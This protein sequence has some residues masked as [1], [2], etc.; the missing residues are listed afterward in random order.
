MAGAIKKEVKTY[1]SQKYPRKYRHLKAVNKKNKKR[2]E[3]Y[4]EFIKKVPL[5]LC[6]RLKRII[7]KQNQ[8]SKKAKKGNGKVEFIKQVSLHPSD[9]LKK[10]Q[11]RKKGR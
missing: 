11:K 3:G 6:E 9:R 10:Q 1:G 5:H 4:V 8:K 7:K 2:H